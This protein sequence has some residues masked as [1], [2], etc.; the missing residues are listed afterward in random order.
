M[1]VSRH[2]RHDLFPVAAGGD[3]AEQPAVHLGQQP[4]RVICG[5]ADH[6]AVDVRELRLGRRQRRHA[7]VEHEHERREVRLQAMPT[8]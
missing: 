7:A 5:A 2:P 8:S 3:V 4:R 1:Q 6:D